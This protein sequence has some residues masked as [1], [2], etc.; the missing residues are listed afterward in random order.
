MVGE[1]AH[2]LNNPLVGERA[3]VIALDRAASPDS[4]APG[5][6]LS[7]ADHGKGIDP[8]VMDKIFLPFFTTRSDGTGLGLPAVR[9]GRPDPGLR[10]ALDFTGWLIP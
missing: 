5:W 2:Q 1:I 7:V 4:G 3:T 8:D 10:G 9:G 6:V